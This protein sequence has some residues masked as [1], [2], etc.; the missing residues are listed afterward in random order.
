M[1]SQLGIVDGLEGLEGEGRRGGLAT[2]LPI[3]MKT[4]VVMACNFSA[5]ARK[6]N[7][8]RPGTSS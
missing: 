5:L 7:S 2:L 6:R 3:G 1:V 4:P 8:V